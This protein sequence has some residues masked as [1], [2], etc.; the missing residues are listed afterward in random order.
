M[1]L[2]LR[3]LPLSIAHPTPPRFMQRKRE[4]SKKKEVFAKRLA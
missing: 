4:A 1:L 2:A 3:H